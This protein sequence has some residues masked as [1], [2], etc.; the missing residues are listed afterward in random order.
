MNRNSLKYI[1]IVAMTLDHVALY[2]DFI[3]QRISFLLRMIGR[4]TMPIMCFF[5][6]EGFKF[7][8]NK[9]KYA[10]R[11]L[12]CALVAQP[13]F[14]LLSNKTLLTWNLILELNT[15]FTLLLGFLLLWVIESDLKLL[16]KA[17]FIVLITSVSF[18]CDYKIVGLIFILFFYFFR[19]N[20]QKLLLLTIMYIFTPMLLVFID[21]G[22]ILSYVYTSILYIGLFFTLPMLYLYNNKSG[23][24]HK[25]HKYSFYVYYPLHLLIIYMINCFI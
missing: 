8:S 3:D 21:K 7:T 16:V 12:I 23:S 1:A 25:F 20:K 10:I 6:A 5:I 14:T 11:L 13:V 22:D 4:I 17:A 19:D 18:L 2:L 15:V 9:K 24:K